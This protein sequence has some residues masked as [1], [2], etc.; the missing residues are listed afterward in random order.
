MCII[1]VNKKGIEIPSKETFK[2][3]WD[4]NSDGSG[5]AYYENGKVKVEKGWFDFEKCYARIKELD[6]TIGLTDRSFVFHAR[7]STSSTIDKTSTHPFQITDDVK[8]FA[9]TNYETNACMFHNGI[10][11][12]YEPKQ[13]S[14]LSDTMCFV[15]DY[16]F[17]LKRLNKDFLYDDIILQA[18][19]YEIGSSKLAFITNEDEIVTVGKYVIEEDG[20][21]YSNDTYSYNYYSSSYWSKWSSWSNLSSASQ[22]EELEEEDLSSLSGK[23]LSLEEFCDVL[24][25]VEIGADGTELLLDNGSKV[26]CDGNI[27]FDMS[28]N[29]YEIDYVSYAIYWLGTIFDETMD[30]L[31][32]EHPTE[33][34]YESCDWLDE[35]E[36]FYEMYLNQDNGGYSES[37]PF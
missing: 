18:I 34:Y 30:S 4:N 32:T 19:E 28:N 1:L 27:C 35:Y 3:M 8:Q 17:R 5:F 26:V 12:N 16:I 33:E 24:D 22:L 15:R 6:E 23:V 10:L 29:V 9:K 36:E 21:M 11:R 14:K 37:Y 31:E 7:I 13:P 20:N 2:N 25:C